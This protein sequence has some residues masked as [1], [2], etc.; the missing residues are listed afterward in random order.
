MNRR[1][2]IMTLAMVAMG[3]FA[4]ATP[5]EAGGKKYQT[6]RVTGRQGAGKPANIV[7]FVANAEELKSNQS[8]AY[9]LSKGGAFVPNGVTRVFVV[10]EGA[11]TVWVVPKTRATWVFGPEQHIPYVVNSTTYNRYGVELIGGNPA[12]PKIVHDSG[13]VK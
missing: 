8:D 10:P 3:F 7:I 4:V 13:V 12:N 5:A 9:Y 1:N 6:V 2:V 11:G